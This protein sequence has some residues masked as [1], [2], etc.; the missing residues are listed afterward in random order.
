[1]EKAY[2][3]QLLTLMTLAKNLPEHLAVRGSLPFCVPWMKG[4]QQYSEV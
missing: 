1:M 4:I 2:D 3:S